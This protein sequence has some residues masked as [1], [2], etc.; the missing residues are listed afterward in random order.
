MVGN[1]SDYWK[2]EWKQLIDQWI[3]LTNIKKLGYKNVLLGLLP[4]T[5]FYKDMLQEKCSFV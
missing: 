3:R 4:S 5:L 1:K 2:S